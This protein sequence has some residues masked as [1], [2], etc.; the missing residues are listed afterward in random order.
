MQ[1]GLRGAVRRN[2]RL[3]AV[4]AAR[5]DVH[6]RASPYAVGRLLVDHLTG[7]APG[8]VGSTLEVD[9]EGTAPSR[10]PLVVRR[11]GQR[12]TDPPRARDRLGDEH[13]GG[14]CPDVDWAGW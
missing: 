12:V 4:G 5:A 6:D 7:H 1:P 13:C 14:G 10:D 9:R 2:I 8:H 11:L 3:T